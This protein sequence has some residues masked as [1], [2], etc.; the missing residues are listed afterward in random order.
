MGS[1]IAFGEEMLMQYHILSGD[2]LAIRAIVGINQ[3]WVV[4]LIVRARNSWYCP[5][6]QAW[7]NW[8]QIVNRQSR[9]S[10]DT[11][12]ISD[13]DKTGASRAILA[14]T[15]LVSRSQVRPDQMSRTAFS[16][17]PKS[18]ATA[19]ARAPLLL[20]GLVASSLIRKILKA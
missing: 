19:E 15:C 12:C 14:S 18:V 7:L 10:V 17:T 13:F 11:D 3:D 5:S 9:S 1:C 8:R 20:K 16:L 2:C 6:F 4:R